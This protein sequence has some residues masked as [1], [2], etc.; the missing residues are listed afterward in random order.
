MTINNGSQLILVRYEG[1]PKGI[2]PDK[3]NQQFEQIIS[4]YSH[5]S[6]NFFSSFILW[7]TF[8]ELNN[9]PRGIHQANKVHM[10]TI[11]TR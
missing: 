1:S 11:R 3:E 8:L 6:V 4:Q 10:E 7:Q 9:N 2:Q 5:C